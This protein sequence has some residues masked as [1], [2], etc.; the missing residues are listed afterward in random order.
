MTLVVFGDAKYMN[1]LLARKTGESTGN[2]SGYHQDKHIE[3]QPRSVQQQRGYQNLTNIVE[4]RACNTDAHDGDVFPAQLLHQQHGDK[5][6]H[7][8]AHAVEKSGRQIA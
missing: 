7:C 4:N 1:H 6:E 8:A 5:A 2:N 3:H